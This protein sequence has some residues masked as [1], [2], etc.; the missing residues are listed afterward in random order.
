MQV[1]VGNRIVVANSVAEFLQL[2]EA[3]RAVWEATDG[4][5]QC[6]HLLIVCGRL[7]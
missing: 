5:P 2:V 3:S 7:G 6:V 1:P 4:S